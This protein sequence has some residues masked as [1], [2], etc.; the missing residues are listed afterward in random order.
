MTNVEKNLLAYIDDVCLP[1]LKENS[2]RKALGNRYT[3][4][5]N[6]LRFHLMH[7]L[8]DLSSNKI[9]L[10]YSLNHAS[11][12]YYIEQSKDM[13]DIYNSYKSLLDKYELECLQYIEETNYYKKLYFQK[14]YKNDR[15]K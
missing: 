4:V 13:S 10:H 12:S 6:M 15:S 14:I 11:V 8:T 1:A 2:I 7:K 5:Y 3:G 9:G